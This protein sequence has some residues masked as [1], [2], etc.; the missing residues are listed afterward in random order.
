MPPPRQ[1]TIDMTAG[2]SGPTCT[3]VAGNGS[4]SPNGRLAFAGSAA[5]H[6][7]VLLRLGVLV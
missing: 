4:R 3:K 1:H 2:S 5:H 7:V 6:S